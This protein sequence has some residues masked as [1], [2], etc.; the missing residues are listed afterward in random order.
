M[1]LRRD[2]APRPAARTP[3]AAPRRGAT[4]RRGAAGR[5]ARRCG[6]RSGR[7][8]ASAGRAGRRRRARRPAGPS[9]GAS[10]RARRRAARRPRRRPPARR[11]GARGSARATRAARAAEDRVEVR[12]EPRDL[13]AVDV[14]DREDVAVCGRPDGLGHVA[15]VEAAAA[16]RRGGG[17]REAC[18][19]R[20]RRR[21]SPTRRRDGSLVPRARLLERARASA[22]RA[23]P[24]SP[25]S[26]R[27]RARPRRAAARAPVAGEPPHRGRERGSVAGRDEER[28]LA[29][30]Q[31]LAGRR[32]VGGDERRAARE[33]LER[34]VRDHAARLGGRAEDAERAAGALD[35]RRQPLVLDPLDPLDVRR[36][37]AQQRVELAAA[38]DA[39]RDL[40]SEPGRGEDRL[41]PVQRDQLADEERVEASGALPAGPEEPLLG[42]DEADRDALGR[43]IAPSSAR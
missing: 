13:L 9:R 1:L 39:E 23:R 6:S 21:R 24:R 32:R 33:R 2:R 7:A 15:E 16:R 43:Q 18:R 11:A 19:T 5:R 36:P 40:R 27:R 17:A 41:E 12:A 28:A 10:A 8:T 22:R 20:P 35:L 25:G 31:Q 14:G 37:L 3:T 29:V 30:A 4:R 38:D 26:G 42:A 34:L